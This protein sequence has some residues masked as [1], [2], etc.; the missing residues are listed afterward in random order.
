MMEVV[1]SILLSRYSLKY[2]TVVPQHVN[3]IVFNSLKG[4]IS[5]A[6][7]NS[8]TYN[9]DVLNEDIGPLM[10]YLA[11]NIGAD[12]KLEKRYDF[13]FSYFPTYIIMIYKLKND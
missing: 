7:F 5:Q 13:C 1:G 9:F 11:Y 2:R 8:F 12:V 10:T 6:F 4:M 3:E